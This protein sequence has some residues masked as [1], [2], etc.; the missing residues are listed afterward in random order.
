VSHEQVQTPQNTPP[1]TPE[2]P[3]HTNVEYQPDESYQPDVTY[4]IH[5]DTLEDIEPLGLKEQDN[6]DTGSINLIQLNDTN[7]REQN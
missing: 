6:T 2:H 4:E 1:H 7:K 5:I 3:Q